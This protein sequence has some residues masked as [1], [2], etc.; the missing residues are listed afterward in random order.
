MKR[1]LRSIVK[2]IPALYREY[3]RFRGWRIHDTEARIPMIKIGG[4]GGIHNYGAWVIPCGLLD[5]NS[6]VYSIGIGE[7]V[8]F[9]RQIIENFGCEIFA[10]DPTPEAVR[11]VESQKMDPRFKF[12]QVGLSDRDGVVEFVEP[13]G[14]DVS[15]SM[16]DSDRPPAG[17]VFKFPVKRLSTLMSDNNHSHI[18]LLK[19]DIE[20]FEYG[21]I[22][23]IVSEGIFPTCI[24]LEYHHFQ[25]KD[26]DSTKRSVNV[27]K[28]A[29]YRLFWISELGAEYGFYRSQD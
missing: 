7:D 3:N 5:N 17:R 29:G 13:S 14:S 16:F 20:G 22:E 21:V 18:D 25:R 6:I 11:F 8:S 10:Y 15:F 4:S 2:N 28:S 27:L 19:M 9:D 23:D 24:I 26:P 12:H 1:L